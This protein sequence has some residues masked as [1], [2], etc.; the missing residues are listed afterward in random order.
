MMKTNRQIAEECAQAAWS[1]LCERYHIPIPT[2]QQML[3][4]SDSNRRTLKMPSYRVSMT[5]KKSFYAPGA[6][7]S[8]PG[9]VVIARNNL[10]WLQ[11]CPTVNSI[12]SWTLQFVEEFT[13]AIELQEGWDDRNV[14][15]GLRFRATLNQ[16]EFAKEFFPHL[17]RQHREKLKLIA[18]SARSELKKATGTGP[19]SGTP[20]GGSAQAKK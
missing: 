11:H 5:R 6:S 3:R 9:E 20:P 17:H 15:E 2:I 14:K 13:R 10:S 18:R 16:I 8:N 4:D 7:P 12:E 1:W 19:I